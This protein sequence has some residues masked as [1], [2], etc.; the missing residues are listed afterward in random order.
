MTT[1]EIITLAVAIVAAVAGSSGLW[2]AMLNRDKTRA[3]AAGIITDKTLQFANELQEERAALLLRVDNFDATLAE[4]RKFYDE[5]ISRLETELEVQA[6][7]IENLTGKNL[8]L[9]MTVSK[10]EAAVE[11]LARQ[12]RTQGIEPLIDP[13]ELDAMSPIDVQRIADGYR[14]IDKRRELARQHKGKEDNETTT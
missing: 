3:D 1:S 13:D 10:L 4:A 9:Q 14:N 8:A 12:L 7:A 2:V 11:I 5:R 6:A